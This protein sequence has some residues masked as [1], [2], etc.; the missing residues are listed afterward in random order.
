MNLLPISDPQNVDILQ[1]IGAL[2]AFHQKQN[3]EQVGAKLLSLK[4]KKMSPEALQVIEAIESLIGRN[5]RFQN[6]FVVRDVK[7]IP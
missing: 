4:S 2:L 6:D 7:I 1:E 5:H 3:Q